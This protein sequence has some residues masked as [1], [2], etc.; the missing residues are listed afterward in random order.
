MMGG[1]IAFP[2]MYRIRH[3]IGLRRFSAVVCNP[4]IYLVRWF[5][6]VVPAVVCG[7]IRKGHC[8]LVRRCC[9]GGVGGPPI[10]PCARPCAR[11]AAR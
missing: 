11:G 4:L 9:G 10:P 2:V 1:F 5:S 3:E 6:A 7:G 8:L